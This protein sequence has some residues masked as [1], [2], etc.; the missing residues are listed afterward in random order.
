MYC[1]NTGTLPLVNFKMPVYIDW[2]YHSTL[3][4]S[5][6]DGS[7]ATA[8]PLLLLPVKRFCYFTICP[9][10][11][12]AQRSLLQDGKRKKPEM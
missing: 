5:A 11:P 1:Q 8:S 4:M 6:N 3:T 10:T 12:Y 7:K 9:Y 2:Y